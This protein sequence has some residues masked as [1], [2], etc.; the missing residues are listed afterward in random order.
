MTAR[1]VI[2]ALAGDLRWSLPLGL[3]SAAAYVLLVV[4]AVFGPWP[5]MIPG[6]L[7]TAGLLWLATSGGHSTGGK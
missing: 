7:W 2:R 3:G 5:L 4:G 6:V 1:R